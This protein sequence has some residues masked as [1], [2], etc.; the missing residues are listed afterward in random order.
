MTRDETTM[1]TTVRVNE[2]ETGR[3]F[4]VGDVHGEYDTLEAMLAELEFQP[5]RDRLFALGDLIDRGPRSV[6]TLEW[7]EQ[8]RITLS[9]RG[10]HEQM[11]L[12]RIRTAEGRLDVPWTM[13]PW[14]P[15]EVER[16][17][18]GRW[19]AMIATMPIAATVRTRRGY[20]GLIH[21]GPTARH[22]EETL[23]KLA[24]ADKDTIEAALWSQA[25]ARNDAR[26]AAAEGVPVDGPIHG[27]R[28]VLTGHTILPKAARTENVWH[29]DTGAGSPTG[30]LTSA[31]IDTDPIETVTMTVQRRTPDAA[32]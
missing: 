8:S 9:V 15:E 18:W 3:D 1:T 16:A 20:I 32:M 27:V 21:A 5:G 22:W 19:K 25:R 6:D 17:D 24:R 7:M 30:H 26:S 28:A 2:N 29:I 10:N 11:L 13:H 12:D 23:A 14:F 31:R 4:V